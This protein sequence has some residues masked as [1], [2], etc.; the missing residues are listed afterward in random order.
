MNRFIIA[1]AQK[2]IGCRTCEVACVVSHQH[3][4]SCSTVSAT[5]FAPRIRVVKS[6]ALSTAT[7]CR[8]CED[9]PCA[10]VCPVEAIQRDRGVWRVDQ[11]RCIGCKSCM[12]ACPYGAMSVMMTGE[13]VQALKCDL[14]SHTDEG[15]ACV[16]ACPTQALRC[17][18][19]SELE[20]LSAERRQR[21]AL[22]M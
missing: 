4:Q 17:M 21:M 2:C 10:N 13:G 18:E 16:A 8:Q 11:R 7:L 12:V 6:D 3:D 20:R 9:A 5:Q 19:P 22:A 15:P 14:C 1:D